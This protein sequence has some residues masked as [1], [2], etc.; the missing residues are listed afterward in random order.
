MA[1]LIILNALSVSFALLALIIMLMTLFSSVGKRPQRL[2]LSHPTSIDYEDFAQAIS[3][4]CNAHVGN[5]NEKPRLFNNGDEYFPQLLEDIKEAKQSINFMI[6]ICEPGEIA[7]RFFAVLV[8]KA[9]AGVEVRVMFDGIGAIN[10]PTDLIDEL[11]AAGGKV[12]SY[13]PIRFGKLTRFYQRNHRRAIVIDGEVGWVG[14]AALAD[15]WMG[16]AEDPEHWRDSMVRVSGAMV[17]S[18]QS[19]FAQIWSDNVGEILV[20]DKFYPHKHRKAVLNDP[21][22]KYISVASSPTHEMHPLSR[23]YWFSFAAAKKSIYITN[24]YFVPIRDIRE[25]LAEKAQSGVDVRILLPGPETDIP[26]VRYAAHR[27]YHYLLSHGVK[28]Y[29]YRGTMMHAKQTVIDREW[30]IVGSANLDMRSLHLNKENVFGVLNQSFGKELEKT[31]FDD[32]EKSDEITLEQWR[33]RP[34]LNR[35]REQAM[36]LFEEQF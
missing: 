12:Y 24:S 7:Q 33:K 13:R 25:M 2:F 18:V 19:A 1:L 3:R 14:G 6:Y 31:F 26:F 16:N 23:F 29:E 10:A 20:G 32:L 9:R 8:A 15:K 27:L 35:V 22:V 11:Q 30:S 34:M 28:I 4:A 36:Y 5:Q 21:K 17:A